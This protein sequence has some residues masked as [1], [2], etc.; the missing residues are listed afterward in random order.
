MGRREQVIAT[1]LG[2]FDR[3]GAA[4]YGENVTQLQHALQC[5]QL[6]RDHDCS[7]ALII[8]ALL[9]DIGRMLEPEGNESE[10]QG[11]DARHEEV[12]AR[13]LTP[14]YPSEVTEPI[15]LHV[16]AKRYFCATDA[17]YSARLSDASRLSL[18]VQGGAMTADEAAA[19]ESEPFFQDAILLRRFDDWGKRIGCEVAGL[20][21]YV[22]LLKSLCTVSD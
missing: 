11:S 17:D 4:Q 7:D 15:R 9:H 2:V 6:A 20:G 14:W 5:A 3:H 16:A 19:L 13:A 8:A 10:L 21:S 18:A 1:I 12:G 22:P